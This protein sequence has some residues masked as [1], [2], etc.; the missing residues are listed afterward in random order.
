VRSPDQSLI[1]TDAVSEQSTH[2]LNRL[3]LVKPGGL[4][5]WDPAVP[6]LVLEPEKV[7]D[8]LV[9]NSRRRTISS[10]KEQLPD[11]TSTAENSPVISTLDADEQIVR[12]HWKDVANTAVW[13][14]SV[15]KMKNFETLTCDVLPCISG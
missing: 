3:S 6:Q 11:T 7:L 14:G 9:R 1:D 13:S 5:L 4:M 2:T 15:Q 10:G 8:A 12:K